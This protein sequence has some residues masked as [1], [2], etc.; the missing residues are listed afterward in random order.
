[1]TNEGDHIYYIVNKYS[2]GT[3]DLIS[4]S[5]DV[6]KFNYFVSSGLGTLGKPCVR[7]D[8]SIVT[9]MGYSTVTTHPRFGSGLEL[10]CVIRPLGSTT[11]NKNTLISKTTSGSS[12]AC[13]FDIK[14]DNNFGNGSNF[15]VIPKATGVDFTTTPTEGYIYRVSANRTTGQLMEGKNGQLLKN[16]TN[17]SIVSNYVDNF[18]TTPLYLCNRG[19]LTNNNKFEV[20]EMIIFNGPLATQNERNLVEGYLSTK[21]G[22]P[23]I[24][25]H[26]YYNTKVIYTGVNP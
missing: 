26:P 22:I 12:V 13:P 23:L 14:F 5:S 11:I 20:G 2:I 24:S 4:R 18:S 3:Y 19:D 15:V 1:M 7:I 6:N 25:T 21:W 10:I 8:A 17:A 9:Q 16:T